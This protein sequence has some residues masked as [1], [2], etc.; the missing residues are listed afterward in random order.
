MPAASVVHVQVSPAVKS[1]SGLSVQVVGPPDS[2]TVCAPE[3]VQ[4][5]VNDPT[6]AVTAS[7]K[8]TLRSVARET[9]AP[10]AGVVVVTD[11]AAS[12]VKL[13]TRS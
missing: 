8:V 7:L 1:V 4:V 5:M 11:G 13:T 10:V 12:A 2:A 6:A 9:V 3:I